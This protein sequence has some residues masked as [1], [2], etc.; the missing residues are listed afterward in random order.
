M[1]R[2]EDVISKLKADKNSEYDTSW[3]SR[4]LSDFDY[5]SYEKHRNFLDR[6]GTSRLSPCIRFGIIS[7]R[8]IIQKALEKLDLESQYSERTYMEGVLVPHQDLFSRN[9]KSGVSGKAQGTQL[10]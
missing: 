7:L 2:I 5:S 8:E 1:G 10:G 6:D 3:C 4:R 9:Q